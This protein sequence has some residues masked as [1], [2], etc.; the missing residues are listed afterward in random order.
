MDSCVLLT[1]ITIIYL[2]WSLSEGFWEADIG[3]T[4]E[5]IESLTNSRL[6]TTVSNIN[7]TSV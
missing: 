3:C 2:L 7:E 4:E 1:L 6:N 5:T